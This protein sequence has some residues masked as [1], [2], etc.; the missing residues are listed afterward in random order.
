MPVT[1]APNRAAASASAANNGQPTLGIM[2]SLR[3]TLATVSRLVRT[4]LEIISLELE[5]QREWLQSLVLLAV[6][7]LFCVT[8]GMVM[9]TL[10]VVA[11]FWES[12]P[13]AVLGGFS[14]LYLG[15]GVW[16]VLTF[17]TKMHSRPKMFATTNGELLKDESQLTPRK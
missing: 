1:T 9:V 12:H 15:V 6:T 7:G 14:A 13:L 11:L 2:D 5:E 8:M 10:F 16:A 3:T 4:R 17:R